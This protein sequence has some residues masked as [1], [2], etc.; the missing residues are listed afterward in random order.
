MRFGLAAL[1]AEHFARRVEQRRPTNRVV[2]RQF[3]DQQA[4]KRGVEHA[5]IAERMAPGL[6]IDGNEGQF[7][8]E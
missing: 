4:G 8:S 6:G 7:F 5:A 2:E 3:D 1:F